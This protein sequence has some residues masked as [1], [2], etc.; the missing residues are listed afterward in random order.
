MEELS[1][2]RGVILTDETVRRWCRTFG[3]ADAN[4]L[5]RRRLRPGGKRHQDEVFVGI[6]GVRQDL[7]REVDRG[8]QAPDILVQA[9]RDERADAKRLRTPPRGLRMCR[10]WRSPTSARATARRG[11]RCG[12]ASR[13]GGTR[14]CTTGPRTRTSPRGRAS[15]AY[16]PIAAHFS[17][18]RHRLTTWRTVVCTPALA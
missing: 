14:G 8:G 7:W 10:A 11:A 6:D 3:Q 5:R 1:A 17:P 9:R 2:E 15:A 13:N 18:R 12:Q 4:E 16:G